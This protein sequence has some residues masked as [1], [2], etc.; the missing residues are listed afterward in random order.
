MEEIVPQHSVSSFGRWYAG[1]AALL[2]GIMCAAGFYA[3]ASTYCNASISSV[4][5]HGIARDGEKFVRV[6]SLASYLFF[7]AWFQL[8]FFLMPM[9][10]FLFWSPYLRALAKPR[11]APSRG[12]FGRGDPGVIYVTQ[13]ISLI[14]LQLV[15]L[16]LTLSRVEHVR[17]G[18]T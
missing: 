18:T 7:D 13:C 3:A 5:V 14:F 9:C 2:N 16:S 4:V 10:V 12:W 6:E 17:F 1:L 11:P 15:V 8:L